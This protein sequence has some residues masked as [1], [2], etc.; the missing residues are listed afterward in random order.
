MQLND[1]LQMER[2]KNA[3]VGLQS[4][5]VILFFA[6]NSN[7][8]IF[9]IA[10]EASKKISELLNNEFK[11]LDSFSEELKKDLV[12]IQSCISIMRIYTRDDEPFIKAAKK[13]LIINMA[14]GY[15]IIP[16]PGIV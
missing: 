5:N 11:D 6:K 4:T 10:Q 7:E 8:K 13:L 1:A 3:K 15:F 14:L 12:K 2:Y 16:A 9:A